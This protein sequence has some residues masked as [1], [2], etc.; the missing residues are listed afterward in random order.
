MNVSLDEH[1]LG[2]LRWIVLRGAG[3]EAFQALGEHMRGPMAAL[4]EGWPLLARLR[5]HVSGPPGS[6]RLNAVRQASAQRFPQAWGE[7]AAFAEGT[8]VPSESP[9]NSAWTWPTSPA[10]RAPSTA[11]GTRRGG[12]SER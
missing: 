7:L 5:E 10:I 8:A 1:T 12:R 2:G 4:A 6:D 3:Y 9:R 11:S